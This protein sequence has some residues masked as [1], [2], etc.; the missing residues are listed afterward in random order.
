MVFMFI[1]VWTG[2]V[3]SLEEKASLH[4][5]SFGSQGGTLALFPVS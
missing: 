4:G 2:D 5:G 3:N 1:P